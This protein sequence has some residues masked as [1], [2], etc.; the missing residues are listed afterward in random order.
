MYV[1]HTA[2]WQTKDAYAGSHVNNR[3]VA[4]AP[5]TVR[6]VGFVCALSQPSTPYHSTIKARTYRREGGREGGRE[7]GREGGR[8]GGRREQASE[9]ATIFANKGCNLNMPLGSC[10]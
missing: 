1:Q 5:L 10:L 7:R 9:R 4:S 2:E 3:H 8:E 6:K